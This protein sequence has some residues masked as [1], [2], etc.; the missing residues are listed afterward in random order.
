MIKN[1]P[2]NYGTYM[3]FHDPAFLCT[4]IA[5]FD[6]GIDKEPCLTPVT[7][8]VSLDMEQLLVRTIVALLHESSL[9]HILY[10]I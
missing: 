6:R 10:N 9:N 7:S 2:I 1:K 8:L 4:Y 5:Q 3:Q